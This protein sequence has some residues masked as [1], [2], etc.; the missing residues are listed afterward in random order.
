M[1]F[2]LGFKGL[3]HT[4]HIPLQVI[5]NVTVLSTMNQMGVTDIATAIQ[6]SQNNTW[7]LKYKTATVIF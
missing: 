4:H 5:Q 6:L 1:G 7:S 3:I 2:N